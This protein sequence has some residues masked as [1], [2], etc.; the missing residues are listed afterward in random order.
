MFA[1]N[2][3]LLFKLYYQPLSAMSEIIDR[4]SW[5][6]GAAAVVAVSVL[7][8]FGVTSDIFRTYQ[9]VPHRQHH[10]QTTLPKE[11]PAGG[12]AEEETQEEEPHRRP[13][14]VVGNLGWRFVS[15]SFG[16]EVASALTLALLYVPFTLLVI[17]FFEDL[18]SLGVVLQRNYGALL[19]CTFMAWAAAHLPVSLAG[20]ALGTL[21]AD[22]RYALE[23]WLASKILFAGLMVF[24]LRTVF[25]AGLGRSVA[26][27]CISWVS[28][29]LQSYLAWLA[30]PFL[31]YCAYCYFQGDVGDILAGFRT[32]QSFKRY[33]E[34]ATVNPRDSE[35][36]YQLGLIH[37]Q[38]HQRGEA[39]KRF[40]RAVEIDPAELDA[41]FQLGRIARIQGRP[42]DALEHFDAVVTRDGQFAQNDIWREIGAT[43]AAAGRY[44]EAR[45]ALERYT[46]RRSYDPEGLYLLGET[47]LKLGEKQRA[48][49]AFERCVEAE[50]TNPYSRHARLRKWRRLAEKQLRNLR[51]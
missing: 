43:Y 18:G 12:V 26:T 37:L 15:F 6:F 8:Q 7:V 49:E 14:P 20:L 25:G 32:R 47:M 21:T 46:E 27:V 22:R 42:Q 31:L 50:K 39:I 44:Q 30:S 33:L 34:A 48:R 36:H 10:A 4:G 23:L 16:S 3:K 13:L 51:T 9:A 19:T 41:H 38:R 29:I 5:L 1:E 2:A 45:G 11:P 35:A 40:K 17:N 24:A 28:V